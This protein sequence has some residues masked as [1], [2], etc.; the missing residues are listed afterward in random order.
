MVTHSL[1]V[2]STMERKARWRECGSVNTANHVGCPVRKQRLMNAG[3][4]L[5]NPFLP[6]Y[7]VWKPSL[8]DVVTHTPGGTS[9]T[10]INCSGN[11]PID[12]A[13]Q[14]LVS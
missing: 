3:L 5:T 1:R 12:I 9:P 2:R 6:T 4:Q 10:Q 14:V 13:I 7:S 8:A 11:T